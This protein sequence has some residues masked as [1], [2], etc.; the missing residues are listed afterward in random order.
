MGE[1][2]QGSLSKTAII[3]YGFGGAATT[4]IM[5]F[6]NRFAMNF[7]TDIAG[8]SAAVIGTWMMLITIFDAIND[9]IIGGMADR[10]NTKWGKYR[11]WMIFGSVALAVVI[12]MQFTN[13]NLGNANLIY[14]IIVMVLFSITF[15]S[16]QVSWQALNSVMA[17]DPNERNRLLASRQF[18]GLVASN[19]IG[20]FTIPVITYFGGGA[21]GWQI[22]TIIF[23][24]VAMSSMWFAAWGARTKDYKDSIPN[25]Q[26]MSFRGNLKLILNNKAAVL[27]G[28]SLAGFQLA[29]N[30]LSAADMYYYKYVAED[31]SII[32]AAASFTLILNFACVP[33]MPKIVRMFGKKKAA[34]IGLLVHMFR[35]IVTMFL[36]TGMSRNIIILAVVMTF[37]GNMISNFALLAMIPDCT[38]YTEYKYG[39]NCAAL[40]N[41]AMTFLQKFG[42]AFSTFIVGLVLSGAGYAADAAISGQVVDAIMANITFIPMIITAVTLVF[43]YCYPITE[44]YGRKMREELTVR[45]KQKK[46]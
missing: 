19:A 15:T 7:M 14:F 2:K 5:A 44:A 13:P 33:F 46:A 26:K 30:V 25:P 31:V 17:T 29:R 41:S 37:L 8:V 40:I 36:G 45:R 1:K 10:T 9:P 21:K 22:I 32:A 11:P 6:K 16:V 42:Q 24:L 4:L 28:L 34:A 43:L 3:S 23:A 35:P 12:V 27:G 20:I 39:T 18:L 38:D